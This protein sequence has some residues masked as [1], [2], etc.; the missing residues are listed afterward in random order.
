MGASQFHRYGR[1]F[2]EAREVAPPPR[3]LQIGPH[4]FK[5]LRDCNY[6]DIVEA[7]RWDARGRDYAQ[8]ALRELGARWKAQPEITL[9]VALTEL[10]GPL[11]SLRRN[12]G[13]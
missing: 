12:A 10:G 8:W 11:E 6:G 4:S 2:A 1:T 9:A 13:L 5:P 7:T 3:S